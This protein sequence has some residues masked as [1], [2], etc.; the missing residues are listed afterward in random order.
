MLGIKA[1]KTKEADNL[2]RE[3]RGGVGERK[4]EYVI[5]ETIEKMICYICE[6]QKVIQHLR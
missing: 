4:I 1:D 2:I 3:R 5:G 6:G